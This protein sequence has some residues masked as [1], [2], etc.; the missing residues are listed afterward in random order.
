MSTTPSAIQAW[1]GTEQTTLASVAT[2]LSATSAGVTVLDYMITAFQN[3]PGTLSQSDQAA[4]DA[5]Q[6]Q[7]Q[8]LVQQVQA[9]NTAAPG[10][11]VASVA[12]LKTA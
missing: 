5:I 6:T 10:T 3:S 1:A 9:I 8:A 11:P 4:L 12:A 7:S 2:A